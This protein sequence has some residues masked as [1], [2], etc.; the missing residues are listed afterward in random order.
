MTNSAARGEAVVHLH[1]VYK[2]YRRSEG[3]VPALENVTF[4]VMPGEL[5]ALMGP[6]GCGKSTTLNVISGVD[7]CDSGKVVIAGLDMSSAAE[8]DLNDLRRSKIGIV[9]QQFY[10]MPL[11]TVEENVALPLSLAGMR[12]PVRV[13]ELL[14]RVGL[15]KRMQHYPTELSGGE[16]QRAAIAR[17]LVHRPKLILADEPT[18]NLDSHNGAAVLELL[19]GMRAEHGTALLLVTHDATVAARADRIL[20]MSDGKIL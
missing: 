14:H 20:Q 19:C 6:S 18:G 16:Q 1:G 7:R 11:L 4:D 15:E 12:D 3:D 2:S 9:F 10:L 17:A 8:S 5:V 13:R